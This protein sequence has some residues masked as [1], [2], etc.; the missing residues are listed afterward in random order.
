MEWFRNLSIRWKFQIGVFIVTMIVTIYN[1]VLAAYELQNMIDIARLGGVSADVLAQLT[2]ERASYIFNSFWESGIE[3][4]VQFFVIGLIANAFV[5]PL[6]ELCRSLLAVEKGDLTMHVTVT[7]RDEIGVLQRI[8]NDVLGK[9]NRILGEVDQSG[10][11][12]GQSAFQIATIA[13][14]IAEVSRQEE[15]RSAEVVR[16][17]EELNAIALETRE[18]AQSAAERT[19]TAEQEGRGAVDM[20]RRNIQELDATVAEVDRVSGE[21]YQLADVAT[22][23]TGI[24]DTIKEIS[25]QTNLLALNAAI[26]AARA[27]EAGRGFTVVADEVRKL[28]ERTTLSASEVTVIVD[29]LTGSVNGAR[30]A[31]G[32]VIDRVHAS[33]AV[34]AET[35]SVMESM[36]ADVSQAADANDQIAEAGQRQ[37]VHFSE[38]QA[39]LERLFS[40]LA[41]SSTKVE[42]TARIGDDLHRVT[43][44]MSD[45]MSGFVIQHEV[46]G[47]FRKATDD[48]R[49]FPRLEHGLL[50]DVRQQVEGALQQQEALALDF[51]MSG[52]RLALTHSIK[53]QLP[54]KVRLHLPS[55]DINQYQQ[56]PPLE[57]DARVAW[58]RVNDGH[59]TAGVEF[60]DLSQTQQERLRSGFEFFN[61]SAEYAG[62]S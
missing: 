1:R 61:R 7:Q 14:S 56:Q 52:A 25:A 51:S 39:S 41:E 34:A 47:E 36:A 8:F 38:M 22:R 58:Q 10:K 42:T 2:N 30:Q 26:E 53:E 13:K 19:R 18:Q 33:Q 28:A 54:L 17:T 43:R 46:V 9:L 20:V 59:H 21:V 60:V 50:A 27:G 31:M 15:S 62:M 12:M 57:L 24:I 32:A 6:Q 29:T 5:R 49:R 16:A 40:T 4:A 37:L 45:L 44:R 48:K 55:G 11:Q 3:F 35:A 23:I